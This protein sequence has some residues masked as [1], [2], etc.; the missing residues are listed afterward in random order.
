M[1][2]PVVCAACQTKLSAPDAA[3]G[4]K[5]KCKNCQAVIL[6][7]EVEESDFEFVDPAPVPAAKPI[8]AKPI[9]AK[10]IT[11]AAV[12]PKLKPTVVSK[13]E[14][15]E[16]FAF[17]TPAKKSN[18]KVVVENDEDD[19]PKPKKTPKIVVEDDE[20]E[21]P[22]PSKKKKRV[23]LDDDEE[24][25]APRKGKKGKRKPEKKKGNPLVFV[26]LGLVALLAVGAIGGS[27]W[28]FAIREDKG[29]AA[30]VTKPVGTPASGMDPLA[31]WT[32]HDKPAF[33]VYFKDSMGVPESKSGV[34]A[35]VTT[36]AFNAGA[37]PG[38]KRGMLVVISAFPPDIFNQLKVNPAPM[39]EAGINAMAKKG[40]ILSS[41]DIQHNGQPGREVK[42]QL[43]D[44][45]EGITRWVLANNR[46]Y[47]FGVVEPGITETSEIYA[48]FFNNVTL[49][50]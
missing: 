2:I 32:K 36:E 26:G 19:E 11:A 5:V 24:D 31:G 1:P 22:K 48:T 4:K 34:Q 9:A 23:A 35:S 49:K 50:P 41:K 21:E 10:L 44:G 39:L 18:S 7:P 30:G 40:K 20:D 25:D 28:Y 37:G 12:P 46:L 15:H 27:V 13:D 33:T 16:E 47:V 42:M 8:V 43:N 6:V 17:D 14:Y 38:S 29:N 45:S 3:A